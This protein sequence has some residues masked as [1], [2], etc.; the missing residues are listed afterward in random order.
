MTRI[1]S[2]SSG[3]LNTVLEYIKRI[4]KTV[5]GFKLETSEVQRFARFDKSVQSWVFGA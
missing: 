4:K 2:A 3:C 1:H 5:G